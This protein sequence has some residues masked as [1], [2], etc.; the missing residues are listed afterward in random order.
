MP[1]FF[2]FGTFAKSMG[3]NIE[4]ISIH[5]RNLVYVKAKFKNM[6]LKSIKVYLLKRGKRKIPVIELI[7]FTNIKS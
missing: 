7:S 2:I 4:K 5:T 3:K 1:S 6:D